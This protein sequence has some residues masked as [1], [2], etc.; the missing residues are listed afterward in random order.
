MKLRVGVVGLGDAWENRHRPAL[1]ALADRFEVSAVCAEVQ[2]LAQ[3]AAEDF[4]AVAVEGVRA[5]TSRDDVDAVLMLAP[6]WYGP[7]PIL[8]ACE[9]GKAI[10]CASTLE[11]HPQKAGEVKRRVENSGV[12]FMA[13]FPYR[14]APATMRLKE[15]IAT[16][17][18]QPQLLFCHGRVGRPQSDHVRRNG[19]RYGSAGEQIVT[20]DLMELVDWCSYVVGHRPSSV[21]GVGSNGEENESIPDYQMMSLGFASDDLEQHGSESGEVIAQISTGNYMADHGAEAVSFRAPA[22]LQVSCENGIAFVDLPSNIIWFDKAG[23]HVE[24]LERE[25]PVG[26]QMLT[27]F[28]RSVTSLV[29][30]LGDLEDAYEALRVVDAARESSRTGQRI[31][32]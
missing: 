18:G 25:R 3:R 23:Q 10:Y 28:H 32:L 2:S 12:A 21:I 8:A 6:E 13:E 1:R 17:L 19:S 14:H 22:D 27:L 15:L 11:I 26:E 4:D 30:Q 24:S 5:L 16:R 29:R 7:L 9:Q 20:H 31:R